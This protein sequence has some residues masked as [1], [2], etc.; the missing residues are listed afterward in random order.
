METYTDEKTIPKYLETEHN[1]QEICKKSH[2]NQT[3]FREQPTL[4]R[5][6]FRSRDARISNLSLKPVI[7]EMDIRYYNSISNYQTMKSQHNN[8]LG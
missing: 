4:K 6:S 3:A 1:F 2:I 8:K 5:T 7:K